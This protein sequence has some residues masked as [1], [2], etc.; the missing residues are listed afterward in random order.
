MRNPLECLK[1]KHK[2][3]VSEYNRVLHMSHSHG[4]RHQKYYIN[5]ER[6]KKE[7]LEK[8]NVMIKEYRSTIEILTNMNWFNKE[9]Y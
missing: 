3:M 5:W 9:N 8:M 4:T 6:E 1:D 2:E 7:Q